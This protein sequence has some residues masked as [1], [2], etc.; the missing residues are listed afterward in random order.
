MR[1]AH[2]KPEDFW[3]KI[4]KNGVRTR[5]DGN[6]KQL[7]KRT[8]VIGRSVGWSTAVG[9][10]AAGKT[11]N[12][13][14]LWGGTEVEN[15]WILGAGCCALCV[16]YGLAHLAAAGASQPAGSNGKCCCN[17]RSRVRKKMQHSKRMVAGYGRSVYSQSGQ[18][19]VELVWCER[20]G[21]R[22]TTRWP[23]RLIFRRRCFWI[24]NEK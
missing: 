19:V 15:G 5:M 24:F 18:S 20:S 21:N 11:V 23:C 9:W 8:K 17:A 22:Q 2:E 1:N 13:K 6:S 7:A 14:E 3:V 16:S 4:K 12:E 10:L